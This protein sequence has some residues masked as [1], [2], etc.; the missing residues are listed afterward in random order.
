MNKKK[1]KPT[2]AKITFELG[3]LKMPIIRTQY[4]V[5]RQPPEQDLVLELH[6]N[7]TTK[8]INTTS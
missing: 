6:K 4:T 5:I 3:S 8:G 2:T 1:S 7:N